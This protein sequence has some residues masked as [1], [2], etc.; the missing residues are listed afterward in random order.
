MLQQIITH[1][2]C[3]PHSPITTTNDKF[4][5]P[6]EPRFLRS[7]IITVKHVQPLKIQALEPYTRPIPLNS[8]AYQTPNVHFRSVNERPTTFSPIFGC[9]YRWIVAHV[10][11]SQNLH[12]NSVLAL[13]L[14]V[15][16]AMVLP[17][18]HL[19]VHRSWHDHPRYH[20]AQQVPQKDP[21]STL[22]S[23]NHRGVQV[24]KKWMYFFQ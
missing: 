11:V 4:G 21:T 19:P 24:N 9:F 3:I 5:P 15:V 8:Q 10:F 13:G 17:H 20:I 18:Q 12:V 2:G 16:V 14:R 6:G 1:P 22:E 23:Q 7:P